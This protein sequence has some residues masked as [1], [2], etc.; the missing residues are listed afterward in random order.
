MEG[1][2]F[3]Y[4]WSLSRFVRAPDAALHVSKDV[5]Q[6]GFGSFAAPAL[7]G[8][9][10]GHIPTLAIGPESNRPRPPVLGLDHLPCRFA[11]H[12]YL[13]HRGRQVL[14]RSSDRK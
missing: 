1:R 7:L 11:E 14:P 10:E 13:S 5:P 12:P 8:G 4:L 9:A 3:G 6:L 2:R